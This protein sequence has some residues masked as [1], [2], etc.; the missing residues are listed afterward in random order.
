M[1]TPAADMSEE[2]TLLN[3]RAAP[4]ESKVVNI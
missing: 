3:R 4:L 2:T 1:Q